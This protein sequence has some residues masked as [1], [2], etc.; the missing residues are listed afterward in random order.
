[1]TVDDLFIKG[2]NLFVKNNFIAIENYIL[3]KI[4]IFYLLNHGNAFRRSKFSPLII[5]KI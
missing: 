5:G 1:M 3:L 4:S 2:S